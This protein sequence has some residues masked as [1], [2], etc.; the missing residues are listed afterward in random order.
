MPPCAT[1]GAPWKRSGMRNRLDTRN[2]SRRKRSCIP[3]ALDGEQPKQPPSSGKLRST[4]SGT[5]T[6]S[7][8]PQRRDG[9][10]HH[11]DERETLG[12]RKLVVELDHLH[13]LRIRGQLDLLEVRA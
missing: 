4:P 6:A 7:R 11:L 13:E 12:L 1:P 5:G 10:A 2:P 9:R 3:A 8:V